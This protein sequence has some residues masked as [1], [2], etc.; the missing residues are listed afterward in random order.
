[1]HWLG[2]NYQS[3]LLATHIVNNR[4]LLDS[5]GINDLSDLKEIKLFFN[6]PFLHR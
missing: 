6:N 5:L 2:E 4:E 1:M 3:N